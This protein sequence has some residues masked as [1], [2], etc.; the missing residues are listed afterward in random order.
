MLKQLGLDCLLRLFGQVKLHLAIV[1]VKIDYLVMI[2]SFD[3]NLLAV[4]DNHLLRSDLFQEE[5][6]KSGEDVF[7]DDDSSALHFVLDAEVTLDA[8]AN[9]LLLSLEE[10]LMNRLEPV[11]ERKLVFLELSGLVVEIIKGDQVENGV[12]LVQNQNDEFGLSNMDRDL[13]EEN[14][15]LAEI[16]IVDLLLEI[17]DSVESDELKIPVAIVHIDGKGVLVGRLIRGNGAGIDQS[18]V[19]DFL[20]SSS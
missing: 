11:V 4:A 7:V 6:G 14:D 8:H 17:V 1:N 20:E 10:T 3:Q 9:D 16:L 5:V 12:D 15:F 2:S 18:G 19:V 13:A